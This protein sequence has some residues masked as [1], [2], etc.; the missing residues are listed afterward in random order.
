VADL[1]RSA[2]AILTKADEAF[3]ANTRYVDWANESFIIAKRVTYPQVEGDAEITGP[4]SN[5][6]ITIIEQ[7]V[8]DA[9]V[10]LAAVLNRILDPPRQTARNV[11]ELGPV[12]LTQLLCHGTVVV[13]QN[14]AETLAPTNGT[15]GTLR[16]RTVDQ[17]VVKALVVSFAVIMGDVFAKRS[18]KMPFTDRNEA[19]ET[20]L[21]E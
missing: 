2:D 21:F 17:L 10:R 15:A 5:V 6:A 1:V 3:L 7:R 4:E 19:V 13:A 8:A 18:S 12:A 11:R 9:G 16:V 20:F 14:T